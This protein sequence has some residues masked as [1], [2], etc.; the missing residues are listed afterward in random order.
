MDNQEVW[1]DYFKKTKL[2]NFDP[3][4]QTYKSILTQFPKLLLFRCFQPTKLL[5][6][7]RLFIENVLGNEFI[8]DIPFDLQSIFADSTCCKPL[9][10][11]LTSTYDPIQN[12]R[13]LA[14]SNSINKTRLKVWSLSK[15]QSSFVMQSIENGTK[16]GDWVVLQNCHLAADWMPVLERIC[17]NL[18]P[19]TTHPDFRLWLTSNAIPN[20]PLSILR[21][22]IKIVNEPPF[23]LRG[24]LLQSFQAAKNVKRLKEN[25]NSL[26]MRKVVFALSYLHAAMIERRNFN[27]LG[28]N[29]PYDFSENDLLININQ[30]SD[31]LKKFANISQDTVKFLIA[32]NIYGVILSILMMRAA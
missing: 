15:R 28:W 13:E 1:L 4:A 23:N 26:K 12:I 31:H 6:I 22:S 16:T 20:F 21:R 8:T 10:F 24:T 7:F 9:L 17:D 11:I 18:A 14:E 3:P 19:D 30:I 5:I 32:E 2:N 27:I 25:E 29:C